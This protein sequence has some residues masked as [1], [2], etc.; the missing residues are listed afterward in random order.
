MIKWTETITWTKIDRRP[1][2]R[3]CD[4]SGAADG[5]KVYTVP[6]GNLRSLK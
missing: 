6:S 4:V 5:W 2:R 3:R 1:K